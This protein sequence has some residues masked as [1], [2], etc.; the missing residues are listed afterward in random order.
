M[1]YCICI[2]YLDVL[3]L[4]YL[5]LVL[6]QTPYSYWSTTALSTVTDAVGTATVAAV[7]AVAVPVAGV[8]M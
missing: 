2:L 4:L 1:L 3:P 8:V 7:A 5:F 6:V